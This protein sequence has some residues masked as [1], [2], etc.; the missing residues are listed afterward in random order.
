[1]VWRKSESS[2]RGLPDYG[3]SRRFR[4]PGS[5]IPAHLLRNQ[6][7]QVDFY[8]QL[9]FLHGNRSYYSGYVTFN[10]IKL[11][12]SGSV[13]SFLIFILGNDVPEALYRVKTIFAPDR[14]RFTAICPN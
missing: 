12:M 14:G 6:T 7:L 2:L 11:S 13:Y 3:H 1:M 10:L 8:F 4:N 5:G 9:P